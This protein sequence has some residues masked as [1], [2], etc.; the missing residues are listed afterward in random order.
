MKMWITIFAIVA[1]TAPAF[2][3]LGGIGKRVQQV[4]ERKQQ[5]DDLN[6]TE[7]EE[8]KLGSDVSAKIRQRF[9]V[10][11]MRPF[12]NTCAGRHDADRADLAPEV[13]VDLHRA[14]YRRRQRVRGA[15]RLRPYHARRARADQVRGRARRRPRHEIAHVAQKHTVN[16]IRRAKAFR[17]ARRSRRRTGAPSSARSRTAPTIWS[18]KLVRSRRRARRG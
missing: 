9:G 18:S 11:Q 3:Q 10:V 16:A 1:V 15:R 8:I 6:I 12:T 17:S 14:G 7:E 2:A 13:T 5:F 4:Q